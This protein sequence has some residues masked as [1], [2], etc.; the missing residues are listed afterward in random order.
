MAAKWS[1]LPGY[2]DI[3]AEGMYALC[4]AADRFDASCGTKF[5]TYAYQTISGY[6]THY[7]RD[8]CN[9]PIKPYRCRCGGD[10]VIY[11][12]DVIC[13]DYPVTNNKSGHVTDV[14]DLVPSREEERMYASAQLVEVIDAL[15][16]HFEQ[17]EVDALLQYACGYSVREIQE[18]YGF[19]E[20]EFYYVLRKVRQY[21]G[22]KYRREVA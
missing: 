17:R 8:H 3:V 9:G 11:Y 2:E 10:E 20:G 5:T 14:Y 15:S 13:L 18:S 1:N 22:K 21:L 19:Y 6:M 7:I 4:V 12:P 16:G